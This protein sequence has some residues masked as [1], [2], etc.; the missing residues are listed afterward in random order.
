[1]AALLAALLCCASSEAAADKAQAKALFKK[2]ETQYRLG[3]FQ[4]ALDGY[5][6]ALKA[7][8]HPSIIFNIAQCHRQLKNPEK[9]LFYYKLFLSDWE[10]VKPGAS[11][12]NRKE[13]DRRIGELTREVEALKRTRA[14]EEQRKQAA[15][16]ARVKAEAEA[17]KLAEQ[18]AKKKAAAEAEAETQRKAE[19][20]RK[21]NE[22][23]QKLAE[24][25]TKPPEAGA[26]EDGG[27]APEVKEAAPGRV[28]VGYARLV[29]P[30]QEGATVTVSGVV[31]GRTPLSRPLRLSVGRNR[32]IVEL[33]DHHPFARTVKIEEGETIDVAVT[34]KRAK[35]PRNILLGSF[36]AAA[37]LT[38]GAQG[39]AQVFSAKYE[40]EKVQFELDKADNMIDPVTH[41][42]PDPVGT[43]SR[44]LMI[45]GHVLTG[46]FGAA[47]LGTLIGF[48][49]TLGIDTSP[50]PDPDEEPGKAPVNEPP[51]VTLE[52]TINGL[53]LRF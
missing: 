22:L 25:G 20:Q 1:V 37:L 19:E 42:A 29:G 43:Q 9:A 11:P 26:P 30:E 16:E 14:E 17:R 39:L 49:V 51:K 3:N 5:M 38:G 18:E 13:V 35:T 24:P 8:H 47:A 52:P 4:Q 53:R 15:E 32:I 46:I 41:A 50:P 45:T 27:K 21:L 36:I 31:M 34:L 7:A 48:F 6:A 10:R 44:D 40:D 33:E 12:P 28:A 23:N 2:A